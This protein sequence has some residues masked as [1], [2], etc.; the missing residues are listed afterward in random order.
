MRERWIVSIICESE[1]SARDCAKLC[2]KYTAKTEH[3]VMGYLE[4]GSMVWVRVSI[5][6]I[7]PAK[8]DT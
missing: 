8:K 1:D 2:E 7:V 4:D 5:A 3:Q 6:E